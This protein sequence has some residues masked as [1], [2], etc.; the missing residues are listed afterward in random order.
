MIRGL[1]RKGGWWW[2]FLGGG[3]V[4]VR[5]FDKEKE[6]EK[7]ERSRDGCLNAAEPVSHFR[8][9]TQAGPP[10]SLMTCC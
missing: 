4:I 1:V 5:L 10:L 7:A 9:T 2:G 8:Q 3:G 6:E